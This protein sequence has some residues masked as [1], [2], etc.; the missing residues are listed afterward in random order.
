MKLSEIREI[1]KD[2]KNDLEKR[3]SGFRRNLLPKL[4]KIQSHALII[5]GVRRCGKSTL[6]HQFVKKQKKLYFYFNFDDL[7]LAEFSIADFGLLDTVIKESG[8]ALLFFDEVQSAERWELYIRQKLDE[9]FQIAITGSNASLLSR[10]LGSRLTGRHISKELFP[11]SYREYCGFMKEE[12]GPESL[13]RYLEKGGFPEYLKTGNSDILVQLQSDILYRD[14]AVRYG[15][16]DVSSL[17]RLFVYV[18]SNPGQLVS[19]SKLTT[20]AGVKSPTTVLEYFSYFEAA[21]LI[22][23]MPC[24]AWSA[25]ASS[26]APKK[27]YIADP[28]L[29]RIGSVAYSANMGAILENFVYNSLRSG[30]TDLYYFTGK[31]GGECDFIVQPHGKTPQCLQVCRDL[32]RDNEER[33]IQGLVEALE[34]FDQ[35]TGCILTRN[36]EDMIHINGKKISVIPAWKYNFSVPIRMSGRELKQSL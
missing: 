6:L 28:G 11:F 9:G 21:Y 10:E 4:P 34:F 24:F 2:Q 30:T 16:R 35:E 12:R 25:K 27:L 20:V 22:Y 15:I 33:E 32:N 5:T 23:L 3:D 13:D 29:I 36:T 14:I 1:A 7:R 8:A 18:L 31:G 19:P 17:R 26:S